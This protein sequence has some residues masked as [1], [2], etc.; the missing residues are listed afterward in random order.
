MKNKYL[1]VMGIV[2][3]MV[4]SVPAFAQDKQKLFYGGIGYF[5]GEFDADPGDVADEGYDILN[6]DGDTVGSFGITGA[7]DFESDVN[8]VLFRFGYQFHPNFSVEVRYGIGAGDDKGSAS[9][10]TEDVVV[11]VSGGTTSPSGTPTPATDV[12]A[13]FEADT[14]LD[15]LYG[16]FLRAGMPAG[17]FYPYVLL[18]YTEGKGE[19]S[20][21]R[22]VA[23]GN[24]NGLTGR[25]TLTAEL[26]RD[27]ETESDLS[28][29][30]GVD[31]RFN[32]SVAVNAEW[33]S[34]LDKDD[35][36]I[37][38]LTLGLVYSF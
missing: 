29:G 20:S 26:E 13:E 15:D 38:G 24:V 18:G 33:I 6:A 23:S 31:Y 1:Q 12:R 21:G 34:Y 5:F 22:F 3:V 17:S 36:Q 8:S 19:T 25:Q 11:N 9:I 10:E 28:Y 27:D 7:D 30:V 4:F 2:A 32:D 37:S 35:A 16:L 14:E